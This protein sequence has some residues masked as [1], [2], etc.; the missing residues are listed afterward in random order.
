[1]RV[2][3]ALPL[4]RARGVARAGAAHDLRGRARRG[5]APAERGGGRLRGAARRRDA[6]LAPRRR[7]TRRR[8]GAQAPRA[9]PHRARPRPRPRGSATRAGLTARTQ[10][11][12]PAPAVGG[13][14]PGRRRAAPVSLR[15]RAL[16]VRA[17]RVALG[18]DARD[19]RLALEVL[20]GVDR[21]GDARRHVRVVLQEPARV[22]AALADPLARV[23]VPGARLLDDADLAGEVE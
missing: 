9:R 20:G 22:L 14:T 5:H 21:L 6:L 7:P 13:V 17:G 10:R 16:R 8:D 19:R 3:P 18:L 2:L 4:A 11:I 15:A 23:R 1:D 12:L